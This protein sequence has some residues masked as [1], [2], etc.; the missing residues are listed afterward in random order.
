MET[1][2]LKKDLNVFGFQV[3]DFP[4]G[5]GKAFDTLVEKVP[6]GFNRSYY[7]ISTM[8][9]DGKFIYLATA[10]EKNPGEA[11]QLHYQRYKIE[12][13]V[14]LTET[15][16]NWRKKTDTIKDIF[17]RMMQDERADKTKPCMEWY[18]NED[19][20]ICMVKTL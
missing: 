16:H 14:Y 18:K 2:E 13:G 8:T 7:G 10:L 12:N 1:Y 17:H 15:V 20:M 5:I 3:N 6:G 4:N 9:K 19:E 11:E